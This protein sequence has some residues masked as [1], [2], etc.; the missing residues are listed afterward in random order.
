MNLFLKWI[1][2]N[3]NYLI[4]FLTPL[5]LLPLPV[6][7]P[8][9]EAGCA[10][11]ISL[12]AVYWCT[13]A[14]P[15]AITAL[16]PVVLFPMMKIMDS[17]AV[18]NQYLK[19]SN[20]LFVGGLL[21]ALAVEQWNL[22]KRIALR[23]L[24]IVGVKPALLMMGFMGTTAFLSMW[25]SNTATTAM[26]VPIAH[27]VLEQL[28]NSEAETQDD[29][30][31]A[32]QNPGYEPETMT[33]KKMEL[34]TN[35]SNGHIFQVEEGAGPVTNS[36]SALRNKYSE[37]SKG[38]SLCVCYAASIG[39][40]ATLTGTTTN[41]ILKGQVDD[42]FKNN[43]DVVNFATWFAFSFPN[44]ILM[45]FLAWFWLQWMYM[46]FN[47][48]ETFGCGKERT[49]RDRKAY[50]VIKEEHNKLGKMTFAE[51]GVLIIFIV[52]VLLWFTRDPGFM[53]GWATDLFKVE[54][55]QYVTDGTVAIFMGMVLFFVPSELPRFFC[56]EKDQSQR[57]TFKA[58]KALMTWDVVHEKMPWNIVLLLG[59][60]FALAKGSEESGLSGWLGQ[61]LTPLQE[62]PAP[63][64][65]LIICILVAFFTEC[66]SNVATTTLFLPILA[67]MAQAI[68]LNPLYVMLPCTLCASMAFMLPVAT[69]PNAIVFSYKNLK[70]IDMVKAGSVLNI[71]GV[72]CINLAL[73]TWGMALFHLD[74]FPEWAKT[75]LTSSNP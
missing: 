65:A 16:I 48:K 33:E 63:A 64:T 29:Y 18:C 66:S 56:C 30:E 71:I 68:N 2:V 51:I 25:I 27:A 12:M 52:L 55:K 26:M 10:F 31:G 72:L 62:I 34:T 35:G 24:L 58:P 15:L 43:N 20:M 6:V 32:H 69:P 13:E 50:N 28:S 61:K 11:V 22:H 73:N 21:I 17:D 38:M 45:L 46:G 47:F 74:T 57:E 53:K 3:K 39:G 19:D 59:G 9:K 60:G 14:L 36:S 54:N 1:W 8:S 41:L 4:M 70:V 49:E 7:I 40:T 44:M 37:L 42:L 23:V 75:N 67:S 5:L